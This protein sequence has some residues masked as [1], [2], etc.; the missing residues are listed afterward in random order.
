MRLSKNFHNLIA[1]SHK[2]IPKNLKI[3]EIFLMIIDED[4]SLSETLYHQKSKKQEG[5]KLTLTV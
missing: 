2:I 4:I 1:I 5:L 3:G